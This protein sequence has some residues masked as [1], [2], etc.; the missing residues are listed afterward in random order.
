MALR[1]PALWFV[2]NRAH[3]P[4]LTNISIATIAKDDLCAHYPMVHIHGVAR[5]NE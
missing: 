2:W 3:D 5:A 4:R 1:K